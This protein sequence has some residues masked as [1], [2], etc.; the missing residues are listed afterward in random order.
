MVVGQD[1]LL[2]ARSEGNY[3]QPLKWTDKNTLINPSGELNER[4]EIVRNEL[5]NIRKLKLH[6]GK[7]WQR[8]YVGTTSWSKL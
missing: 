8:R 1:G 7:N 4:F 5:G 3:I 2:I 6:F